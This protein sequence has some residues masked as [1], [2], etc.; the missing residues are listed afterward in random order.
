[1]SFTAQGAVLLRLFPISIMEVILWKRK[2]LQRH[3][4]KV[5]IAGSGKIERAEICG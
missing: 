3:N 4:I 2:P 1:L 5:D